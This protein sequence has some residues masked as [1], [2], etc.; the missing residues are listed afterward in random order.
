MIIADGTIFGGVLANEPV[1]L[2]VLFADL[3]RRRQVGAPAVVLAERLITERVPHRVERLRVWAAEG[4]GLGE[5]AD[6][7]LAAGDFVARLNGVGVPVSLID[8]YLIALCVREA[9][10][11][12]SLNPIFDQVSEHIPIDRFRPPGL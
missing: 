1:G 10:Q 5:D 7:W 3:W 9:T 11:L 4:P 6:A 8:G 2:S 12:W